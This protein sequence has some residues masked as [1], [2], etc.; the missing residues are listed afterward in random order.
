MQIDF[1]PPV[2]TNEETHVGIRIDDKPAGRIRREH[3]QTG[4]ELS[5]TAR[6]LLGAGSKWSA[7]SLEVAKNRVRNLVKWEEGA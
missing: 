2:A 5:E 4:W 6:S 1:A 3:S 7:R